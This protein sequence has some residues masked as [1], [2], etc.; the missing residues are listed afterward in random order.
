LKDEKYS[1]QSPRR[2]TC[3]RRGAL[4]EGSKTTSP[5]HAHNKSDKKPKEKQTFPGPKLKCEYNIKTDAK[6]IGYEDDNWIDP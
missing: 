2:S 4:E 3:S 6:Y 1:N 5:F